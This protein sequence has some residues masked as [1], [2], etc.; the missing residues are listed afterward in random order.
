MMANFPDTPVS[1][2][3]RIA[4]EKTG[5]CDEAAWTRLFE[6]YAPA[7]RAFADERGAGDEEDDVVQEIFM[8]LVE[9][10]GSGRVQIG[11]DAGK[12]R[13]YLATL[14]RNEL[15][16]RW[17]HRQ[18]RGGGAVVSLDDPEAGVEPSVDSETAALIDAKW[19]LARRKA[20]VEWTLAKTALSA[21]SKAVYRAYVVEGRPIGEVAAAFGIPRNSV[22][23][24]KTRVER[25]IAAIESEF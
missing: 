2:L 13:R 11:G 6:L 20:A 8:K 4:S 7:I 5:V 16:S 12:F 18:A 25:M 3:V 22:S 21:Q 19:R 1:L 23:Q 24:I 14:V 15:V 10:L 17:R 9:V